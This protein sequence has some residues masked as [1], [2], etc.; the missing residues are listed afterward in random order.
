M[1][2]YLVISLFSI[3]DVLVREF[4]DQASCEKYKVEHAQEF[5]RDSDIKKIEC[6]EGLIYDKSKELS[7]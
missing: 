1:N 6:T 4:V 7:V 3:D 2:W 5:K